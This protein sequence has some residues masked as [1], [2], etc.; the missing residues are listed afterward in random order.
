MRITWLSNY[1]EKQA[2]EYEAALEFAESKTD[3]AAQSVEKP[4]A[5]ESF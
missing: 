2:E 5:G 3:E 4:A 1:K